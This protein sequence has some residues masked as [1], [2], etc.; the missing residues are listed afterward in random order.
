MRWWCDVRIEERQCQCC[1]KSRIFI[2]I[3]VGGI[4]LKGRPRKTW[5]QQTISEDMRIK[6]MKR[7]DMGDIILSPAIIRWMVV[8]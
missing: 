1:V 6:C 3:K 2:K 5:D 4:G 7:K 8:G